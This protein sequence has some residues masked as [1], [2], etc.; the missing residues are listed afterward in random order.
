MLVEVGNLY[1][2]ATY[3]C[4]KDF[5]FDRLCKDIPWNNTVIDITTQEGEMQSA[6]AATY[7]VMTT[8]IGAYTII[9]L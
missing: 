9:G 6:A 4:F 8:T 3:S 1:I 2:Y 5:R 7:N